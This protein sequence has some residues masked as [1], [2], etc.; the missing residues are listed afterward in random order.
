MSHFHRVA[1]FLFFAGLTLSIACSDTSGPGAATQLV[2]TTQPVTTTAGNQ[3]P[4]ITV[5]IQDDRGRTVTSA[6]NEITLAFATN[7]TSELIGKTTVAAV[8]GVA[9]FSPLTINVVGINYAL[10]ATAPNLTTAT[11]KQFSIL[12]GPAAKLG[13]VIQPQTTLVNATLP[14]I[15]V[16][17]QDAVGNTSTTATPA[18]TLAIAA[19]PGNGLT[20]TKTIPAVN[21]IATFLGLIITTPG[22]GYTL[23]AT[24]SGLAPA[25]STSFD[26]PI[27]AAVRL[28]FTTQPATTLPGATIEPAVVIEVRDAAGN[29]VTTWSNNVTIA[30]G[31]GPSGATLS[32]TTTVTP[33]NGVA[34]FADLSINKEGNDYTLSATSGNLLAISSKFG[35]R[36]PLVFTTVTAGYFH[37]CA[38]VAG[39]DAYCWGVIEGSQGSGQTSTP[40]IMSG[41]RTY[42]SIGAGRTHTCAAATGGGGYC[43]GFN[44]TGELGTGSGQTASP[45]V[46]GGNLP[47]TSVTGGYAH[48]CGVTVGGDG[49]CWGDN[50]NGEVGDG[51]QAMR[52]LPV[53]VS[54]GLKFVSISPGRYFTCGLTTGGAAY[55]WG[56]NNSGELGDSTTASST[57]PVAVRGGLSFAMVSTGGF[58]ACGLTTAGVAYCW[59]T[60]DYGQLG[61]GA[62]GFKTGPV[63]VAGGHTFATISAGNRHTCAVTP[64]GVAYCW[65]DNSSGNLG[66]DTNTPRSTPVAVAGGLTFANI[67]A[68]R[69]HSCGVTTNGRAY[70]WGVN[71]N[72][73][74]GDGTTTN[75]IVPVLV[76]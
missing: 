73:S 14:P 20:G 7:T 29:K 76:H 46:V 47:F 36:P 32:G 64:D 2:F 34:T 9:T 11:S 15:I 75:R 25:T 41:S 13:F 71:G 1:P 31:A 69:F 35:V 43:W 3:L 37:S 48:S 24:T 52:I 65:G 49:Y 56:L 42:T 62:A 67:S 68:G 55:C 16:A 66:D 60:D 70:C 61:D 23:T 58:H 74:L 44:G 63:A 51:T 40:T 12:V 6:N 22:L 28:T 26:A 33:V 57:T 18:I 50:S 27:G 39:G 21:G 5:E 59:G 53:A 72:G 38:L 4:A 17:V 8:N 45:E 19:G 30:I 54:G 10:S